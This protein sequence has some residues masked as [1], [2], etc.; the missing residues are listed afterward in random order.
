M[1]WIILILSLYSMGISFALYN[2]LKKYE[3]LEEYAEVAETW[4]NN[5]N[6][7]LNQIYGE[8]KAID[9]KGSFEADDEVG[10]TFQQI[11]DMI[12]TLDL[13]ILKEGET[14]LDGS[15]KKE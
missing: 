1:E 5:L 4:V 2:I 10:S 3:R 15:E 6:I 14:K 8:I 9:N 13:F 12:K 7:R 11:R